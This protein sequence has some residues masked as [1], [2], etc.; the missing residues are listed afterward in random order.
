M[1]Q[2]QN[3]NIDN[4]EQ[5]R[6]YEVES[7]LHP[8]VQYRAND[9]IHTSGRNTRVHNEMSNS[10]IHRRALL[11]LLLLFTIPIPALALIRIRVS[12]TLRFRPTV[13][14]IKAIG[15]KLRLEFRQFVRVRGARELPVVCVEP[16]WLGVE[17]GGPEDAGGCCGGL[18]EEGF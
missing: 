5:E 4:Q 17:G 11:A 7:K 1:N 14:S 15:N 3:V 13:G 16:R 6:T 8:P 18:G 12:D 2:R 10:L 9:A